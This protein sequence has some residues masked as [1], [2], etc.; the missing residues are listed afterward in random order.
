MTLAFFSRVLVHK[1]AHISSSIIGW[2]SRVGAWTRVDACYVGEDVALKDE[3][4]T[5]CVTVL[6]H[7]GVKVDTVGTPGNQKIVI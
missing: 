1:N 2:D 6:P 3:I 4:Y 7:K 5:H